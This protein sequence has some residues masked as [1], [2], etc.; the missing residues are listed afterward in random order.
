MFALGPENMKEQER[1]QKRPVESQVK[2]KHEIKHKSIDNSLYSIPSKIQN[3]KFTYMYRN[4][5][6]QLKSHSTKC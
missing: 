1:P 4:N 5:T 2:G 6:H 3:Q